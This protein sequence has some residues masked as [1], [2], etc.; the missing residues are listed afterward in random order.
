MK[1]EKPSI[2]FL[3]PSL[4]LYKKASILSCDTAQPEAEG[5]TQRELSKGEASETCLDEANK[6]SYKEHR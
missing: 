3:I 1:N 5:A 6:T 4:Y 2:L